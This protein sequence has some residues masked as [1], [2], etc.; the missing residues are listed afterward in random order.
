MATILRVRC[1]VCKYWH[2]YERILENDIPNDL[3]IMIQKITSKGDRGIQNKYY[4]DFKYKTWLTKE[5]KKE[6]ISK[7]KK[8]ISI[9]EKT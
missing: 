3:E 2:N 9:L 8:I 7:L 5:L 4:K 6:L 1:P